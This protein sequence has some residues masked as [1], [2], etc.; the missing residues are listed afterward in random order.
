MTVLMVRYQV[1]DDS[2]A[3]VEACVEE[4]MAAIAHER[5]QGL[6]YALGKLPDGVTFVGV[7]ELDDG[8]ENPLPGIPA[9][10]EF[11]AKLA[12]WVVGEPPV[13]APLDVVG[14]YGPTAQRCS[15]PTSS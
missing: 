9:A 8:V 1:R 10:R 3:D 2:V 6:R 15:R 13:P 11:Q 7:V 4:M 14:S 5:P 12:D